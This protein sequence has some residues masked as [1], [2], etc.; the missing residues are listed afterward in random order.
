V[1]QR[2]YLPVPRCFAWQRATPAADVM[3]GAAISE[4][5][6]EMPPMPPMLAYT[7]LGSLAPGA[8]P[9]I[10]IGQ[11]PSGH[12][13]LRPKNPADDSYWI[14]I[15]DRKDPR[16]IVQEFTVLGQNNTAVPA[17][18]DTYMNNNDYLF[19]VVTQYLSTLHVPQGAFYDYLVKFG[20][21]RE[22]QRLEQINTSVGCGSISRLSYLLT[23]QC[24]TRDPK[25]PAPPSYELGSSLHAVLLLM[26]LMPMMDGTPPYSI[27]DSNTFIK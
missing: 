1:L 25:L 10:A 19:A 24:G 14:V 8:T 23:G 18:L 27:C 11:G 17:G 20:A 12:V 4:M 15:L 7:I 21:G 9:S 22:L 5:K 16:K 6:M 26:S 13:R 2:L 3:I